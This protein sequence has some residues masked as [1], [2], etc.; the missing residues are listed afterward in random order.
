MK[1]SKSLI[2][3][4]LGG[5]AVLNACDRDPS[6]PDAQPPTVQITTPA[7]GDVFT[8]AATL[9]LAGTAGDDEQL[10][11]VEW[12]SD[13]GGSG[14][15]TGLASWTASIPLVDGANVITVTAYD[16]EGNTGTAR[17]TATLDTQQPALEIS[18]PNTE[19]SVASAASS[20]GVSGTSADNQGV[21]ALEWS[22]SRGGSGTFSPAAAWTG[23]VPLQP[24]DNVITVTA[25]DR[26]GNTA[27]D[28]LMVTYNPGAQIA[29]P[30]ID[31]GGVLVGTTTSV[32]VTVPLSATPGL[33]ASSVR[34]L[35]VDE[36][37]AVVQ[38]LGPLVD[39]GDLSEGDEILGDGVFSGIYPVNAATPGN[40]R[41]RVTAETQSGG[42]TVQSL[43]PIAFLTVY[44]PISDAEY[45][46]VLAVQHGAAD[47]VLAASGQG[48][49]NAVKA[50][51]QWVAARPE[52]AKAELAG[53]G[54]IAI[55]YQ[56]GLLGGIQ[57]LQSTGTG[58][59]SRGG[60][61]PAAGPAPRPFMTESFTSMLRARSPWAVQQDTP[62]TQRARVPLAQQ[63]RGTMPPRLNRAPGA[64]R[65]NHGSSPDAVL[66]RKV[67]IYAPFE[68]QFTPY[69]EGNAVAAILT[70]SDL[71]FKVTHLRDEDADVNA[72]ASM[73]GYGL[74][75]LATHGSMGRYVFT[76]EEVD[77]DSREEHESLL[78][79]KKL[80][81]MTSIAFE[82]QP[83]QVKKEYFAATPRFV[84][85]LSGSF[86]RSIIVNNSCES[87]MTSGLQDAFTSKGARTYFG[88]TQNVG[89]GFAV[90][91]ATA[92]VDSLVTKLKTTG[93]SF[94]AGLTDP[95]R[96]HAV[97]EMKGS[98][99]AHFSASLVN[100]DFEVGTLDAWN[101]AGDGRVI[102]R[103]GPLAPTGGY[104]GV[105]STGL[106][107]TTS[108]GEI[109]QTFRVSGADSLL[110]FRWNFLSEEFMEYVGSIYQDYFRVVLE[111]KGGSSVTLFSRNIDQFASSF[112]LA[113]VS[114]GISFD[115]GGVY[116]TG[117]QALTFDL[118][119][120][121]GK[122]VTLRLA[123]GDVGDSIFD[124][125]V[126][127]DDVDV[128]VLQ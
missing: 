84:R 65:F 47:R 1:M 70:A 112:S 37:G 16:A 83:N 82:G 108:T 101:P 126:L 23:N 71:D 76:G 123:V 20:Y 28:R 14:A 93:Q 116:M 61:A 19:K 24:G 107:Y 48:F 66:N 39:S 122:T 80:A 10:S 29:Q 6:R 13:K 22:S 68:W 49:D 38:Q 117:W 78:R 55:E 17:L 88:Y 109:R 53:G 95:A 46:Q 118:R 57:V 90:E 85:G 110:T 127:L 58:G 3:L 105:I 56:S 97:W 40:L 89:S 125:A 21:H 33:V 87:T 73:T 36:S 86:P 31:P 111:V 102:T 114:P 69:N 92:L 9:A 11:R 120:Y 104:M 60:G 2:L 103:L 128:I 94:T 98:D 121:R 45:Q 41:L 62:R 8:N 64:P 51:L 50:A 52:V 67:L 106:G 7:G 44:E 119:P 75:V 79:E 15:V 30:V 12:S 72:L 99:K 77:D 59:I 34:L 74:V 54:M 32:R 81:A 4:L 91:R 18:A 5:T 96:W 43:S 100:G 26:A 42:T 27:T 115:Q 63:T 113:S 25:R 124:S 35:R